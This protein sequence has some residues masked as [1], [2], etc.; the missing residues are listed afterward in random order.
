MSIRELTD[1]VAK[2]FAAAEDARHSLSE[3]AIKL[4]VTRAHLQTYDSP[5]RGDE[6][7]EQIRADFDTTAKAHLE[8]Q[9]QVRKALEAADQARQLARQRRAVRQARR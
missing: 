7:R 3:A 4:Y 8:A 2:A 6:V 1:A 9:D 5:V